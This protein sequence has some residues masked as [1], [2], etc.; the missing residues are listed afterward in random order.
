MLTST[1]QYIIISTYIHVSTYQHIDMSKYK[2]TGKLAKFRDVT[3]GCTC[4]W[5]HA[6]GGSGAHGLGARRAT[7]DKPAGA[8]KV[9]TRHGSDDGPPPLSSLGAVGGNVKVVV[10]GCIQI[11]S[12]IM[13]LPR[14]SMSPP[15]QAPL[16]SKGQSSQIGVQ[17]G[18]CR[19]C[20]FMDA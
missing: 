16:S 4:S 7:R 12:S 10:I 20:A 8:I 17:L 15:S 14:R 1:Y 11:I 3:A 5:T 13:R 9:M 18:H 19:F 2:H 6:P